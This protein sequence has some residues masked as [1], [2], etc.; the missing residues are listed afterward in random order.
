MPPPSLP[1][2]PVSVSQPP[3]AGP[4]VLP[5]SRPREPLFLPSSQTDEQELVDHRMDE[6]HEPPRTQEPLFFPGTQL[7]QADQQAIRDSGLG[8]EN[9]TAEELA[10]MLNGDGEDGDFEENQSE[11]TPGGTVGHGTGDMEGSFD[12]YDETEMEPTQQDGGPKAF[13]PLFED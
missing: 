9:M 2:A 13:R 11:G 10:E 8:I 1:L 4:S 7:S 5:M 3:T 6:D 12:I